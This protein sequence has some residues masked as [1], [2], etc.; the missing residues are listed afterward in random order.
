MSGHSLAIVPELGPL[1]GR[2][3]D[4]ADAAPRSGLALDD[5]R[6]ALV[7]EDRKSVV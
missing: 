1:L 2:L 3:T 7:S 4:T 5:I 6:Y